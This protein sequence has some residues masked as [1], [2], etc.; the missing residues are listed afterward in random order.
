MGATRIGRGVGCNS[1]ELEWVS[2]FLGA[3]ECK[4]DWAIFVASLLAR[5]PTSRE[6]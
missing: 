2:T 6:D 4:K 5:G 1:L 3:V